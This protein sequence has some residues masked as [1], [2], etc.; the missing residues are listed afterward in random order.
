MTTPG[1]CMTASVVYWIVDL[2]ARLVERWLPESDRPEILTASITWWPTGAAA[3][4][5]L[6]LEPLFVESVGE[7]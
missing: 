3:A 2:E 1:P 7:I 6:D 5:G 4:R